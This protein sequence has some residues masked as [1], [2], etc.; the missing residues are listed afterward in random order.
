MKRRW[1]KYLTFCITTIIWIM[2][3]YARRY[4][5]NVSIISNSSDN[6]VVIG[7][8]LYV[9]LPLGYLA[10]SV[11]R[12]QKDGQSSW[13]LFAGLVILLTVCS[14][15]FVLS[16]AAYVGIVLPALIF[17]TAVIFAACLAGL[18][19]R[20]LFKWSAL[21]AF[22]GT[23]VCLLTPQLAVRLYVAGYDFPTNAVRTMLVGSVA[24]GY[25][26]SKPDIIEP[27]MASMGNTSENATLQ[28]NVRRIGFIYL[29]YED[30]WWVM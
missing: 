6:L 17:M 5:S 13:L 2:V 28:V 27:G 10:F 19:N 14:D 21:I 8:V 12:W 24:D 20:R 1:P 3:W 25:G 26:F 15:T 7:W 29:P 30:Q 23:L 22:V 11:Y 16:T 9:G 18:A 4:L